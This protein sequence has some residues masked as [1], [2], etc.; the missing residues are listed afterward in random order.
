[1]NRL[2]YSPLLAM[3]IEAKDNKLGGVEDVYYDDRTFV[4]RY[5]AVDTRRWLPGRKVLISPKSVTLIH[6]PD[7]IL[8]TLTSDEV[9]ACPPLD[10][11][12]PISRQYEL[13][14]SQHYGWPEY[15][16]IDFVTPGLRTLA[17]PQ[18]ETEFPPPEVRW[19]LEEE[20]KQK[21]AGEDYTLRSCSAIMKYNVIARDVQIGVVDDLTFNSATWEL[22]DFVVDSDNWGMGAPNI[23][24][25]RDNIAAISWYGK[26]L[27]LN[28]TKS[29]VKRWFVRSPFASTGS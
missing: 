23:F 15:W 22:T 8:V 1:M 25:P 12:K 13:L 2:R 17:I 28:L 3:T 19:S 27:E 10:E 14:L 5:F 7:H 4:I 20:R 29:Q 24:I 16:L 9:R 21:F 6:H 11:H 18:S 26:T